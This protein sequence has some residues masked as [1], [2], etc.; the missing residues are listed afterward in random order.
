M[1]MRPIPEPPPVTRA[2]DGSVFFH[3]GELGLE[4]TSVL[5]IKDIF[6]LESLIVLLGIHSWYLGGDY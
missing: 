6:E 1:A 4:N 5:D 2:T 3:Y